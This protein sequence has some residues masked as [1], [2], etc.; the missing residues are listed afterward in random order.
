MR[1]KLKMNSYF[2]LI[3]VF[4][5]ISS[6]L[7]INCSYNK[8]LRNNKFNID[9]FES[10]SAYPAESGNIYINNNWTAAKAAGI[11]TGNGTYSEPYIIEDLRLEG[12]GSKWSC[13]VIKNSNAFFIIENCTLYT[14]EQ[15]F[16]YA[17]NMYNVQNG[18][19]INNNCSTSRTAICL[20]YC[21]NINLSINTINDV[22]YGS[23]IYLE[24]SNNN[25]ILDN[26]I[27]NCKQYGIHI[28]NSRDNEVLRNDMKGCGLEITGSNEEFRSNSIESTNTV[29]GKPLYYYYDK[30]SLGLD[31]FTN[32]G[33]VILINCNQSLISHVN[34]I[35]GS[36]GI[37]LYYCNNNT[38]TEN[39]ASYNRV[40]G[41]YLVN[42]N[43]NLIHGNIVNFTYYSY[44]SDYNG[45]SLIGS[46]YNNV[47]K[48]IATHNYCGV[49]LFHSESNVISKNYLESNIRGISAS[50]SDRNY[51]IE[52]NATHNNRAGI[53]I[54]DSDYN[55]IEGNIVTNGYDYGISLTRGNYNTIHENMV[56]NNRFG[57]LI[58]Y[59]NYN[60]ISENTVNNNSYVGIM[61]WEDSSYNVVSGNNVNNNSNYGIYLFEQCNYNT[62][63]GNFITK[64][65]N[66]GIYLRSQSNHNFISKNIL[67]ENTVCIRE[68]DC[69]SN[70]FWDNGSYYYAGKRN[71]EPLI[72][73]GLALL[74]ITLLVS[75]ER[76]RRRT[77][78][79]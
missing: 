19:V 55:Q 48:N 39:N 27:D 4:L 77:H 36:K 74:G 3:I 12:D 45:I 47:T 72:Y 7:S 18:L 24:H 52:N 26:K 20:F 59:N 70:F 23:G 17:I 38:I 58:F 34:T 9:N 60:V 31:N 40:S 56:T 11:C 75:L 43:F 5:I 63:S 65:S 8:S 64:N 67:T 28:T 2:L 33:Q 1:S 37:S 42:S 50:Y 79:F 41:I 22:E 10:S 6:I 35:N 73:V 15:G 32:A 53:D 29:N 62:I 13:I 44:E 71:P 78:K 49:F 14:S 54:K 30:I 51:I 68:E 46:H 57:I 76:I 61:L 16:S 66:F 21:S 25:S 69:F